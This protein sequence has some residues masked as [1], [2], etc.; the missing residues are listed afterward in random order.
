MTDIFPSLTQATGFPCAASAIARCA[1]GRFGLLNSR[2]DQGSVPS[3]QPA[4]EL[5]CAASAL[6]RSTSVRIG[7]M[8]SRGDDGYFSFNPTGHRNSL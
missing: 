2:R 4:I 5:L 8:K 6:A 7:E 1:S 3:F